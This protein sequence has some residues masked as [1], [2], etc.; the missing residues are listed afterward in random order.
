MWVRFE[1]WASTMIRIV[2]R[3]MPFTVQ[4]YD[5]GIASGHKMQALSVIVLGQ[6]RSASIGWLRT[7]LE[8]LR[9]AAVASKDFSAVDALKTA[10]TAAG[11]EVRMSKEGVELLPGPD[12]DPAKLE[13]LQ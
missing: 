9:A 1:F 10:L 7:R 5:N 6:K 11:V 13:A 4:A 2:E 12:F 3:F 8:A